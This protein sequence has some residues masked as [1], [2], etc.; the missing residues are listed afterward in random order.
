MELWRRR[1]LHCLSLDRHEFS[2]RLEE[3]GWK[4]NPRTHLWKQQEKTPASGEE[5]ALSGA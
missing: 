3:R 2:S 4:Y 1:A 5:L